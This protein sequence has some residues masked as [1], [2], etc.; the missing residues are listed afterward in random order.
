[1]SEREDSFNDLMDFDGGEEL[2]EGSG[3]FLETFGCFINGSMKLTELTLQ[4]SK[5][6]NFTREEILKIYKANLKDVL[7][8]M[9]IMEGL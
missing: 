9:S 8:S 5:K 2:P 1:M 7:S 3:A 4:Y 6:D